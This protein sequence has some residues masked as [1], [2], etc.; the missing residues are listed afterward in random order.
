M[1]IFI[2]ISQKLSP[3]NIKEIK[4][5]SYLT[6]GYFIALCLTVLFSG[7]ASEQAHFLSRELYFLFAPFIVLAFYKAEIN[8]S[9]LLAIFW[10][11]GCQSYQDYILDMDSQT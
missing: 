8:I 6:A 3:F 5:F 4:V 7:S 10:L 9:Y 11:I 1:G 2:A